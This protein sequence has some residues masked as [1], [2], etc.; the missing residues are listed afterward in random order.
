MTASNTRT[1]LSRYERC[2]HGE[3]R[4]SARGCKSAPSVYRSAERL[5]TTSTARNDYNRHNHLEILRRVK[6]DKIKQTLRLQI[7][8]NRNNIRDIRDIRSAD[9][10]TEVWGK[11]WITTVSTLIIVSI[12]QRVKIWIPFK[13]TRIPIHGHCQGSII[14]KRTTKYAHEIWPSQVYYNT[15]RKWKGART[16]F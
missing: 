6:T 8:V 1:L 9:E 16:K 3:T 12:L 13:H 15:V 14:A 11:V 10:H 7:R 4:E 2:A 5:A